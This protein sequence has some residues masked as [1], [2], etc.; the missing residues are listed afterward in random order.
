MPKVTQVVSG[1][2]RMQGQAALFTQYT[3]ISQ[4]GWIK[5]DEAETISEIMSS[6]KGSATQCRSHVLSTFLS[7]KKTQ[8]IQIL[9]EISRLKKILTPFSPNKAYQQTACSP[10]PGQPLAI[11][12]FRTAVSKDHTVYRLSKGPWGILGLEARRSVNS[13]NNSSFRPTDMN[14]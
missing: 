12:A 6:L 8:K 2:G 13:A 5:M 7:F 9:C 1:R 14:N 3:H 11:P 4:C 10:G